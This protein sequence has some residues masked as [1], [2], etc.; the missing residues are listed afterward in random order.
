M[1]DAYPTKTTKPTEPDRI[2][3]SE[4][5]LIENQNPEI[6]YDRFVS[7]GGP[8]ITTETRHWGFCK[9]WVETVITKSYSNGAARNNPDGS[10]YPA[11]GFLFGFVYGW[12]GDQS[13]C[14]NFSVCP[15]SSKNIS[16]GNTQPCE[17][18]QKTLAKKAS[19]KGS[20]W[21]AAGAAEISSD[22][23][24]SGHYIQLQINV[25]RWGCHFPKKAPRVCGWATISAVGIYSPNVIKPKVEVNLSQ[26]YLNDID[27]YKSGNLDGTYYLEDAINI[28]HK[29]TYQWKQD[30]VGTLS[31]VVTKQYELSLEEEFQCESVRCNHTLVHSGFEPW[32]MVFEYGSGN[33]LYNA[34][35]NSEIRKHLLIYKVDLYNLGRLIYS[36]QNKTEPLVVLYEPQYDSYPYLILKDEHWWSWAN[37]QGVALKYEGSIGGGPDDTPQIHQ[38]RRSKINSHQYFGYAFDP[39]LPKQL[40]QTFLWDGAS[41]INLAQKCSNSE[42][43]STSF[44]AKGGTAMFV[45]AGFGKI[46]FSWPITK[47][48]LEKRYINATIQN[49]L[50]SSNFAGFDAKNL[51][52]YKYQYPDVKFQNPVK[53]LTYHSDGSRTALPVSVRLVPD[54]AK[55]AQYTQD[56]TCNK[57]LRDTGTPEFADIIVDGMYEKENFANGT[58]YVNMKTRLTSTWFAPFYSVIVNDTLDLP[59]DQ[60]YKALSPYEITISVGE[61]TRT[62]QR[63]VN[64]LS[65]FVHVVNLDSDNV[66]NVTQSFGFV[67]INPDEKFGEIAKVIINGKEL[68]ADCTSGCTTTINSNQ[69]LEIEAWNVWGGRAL[70]HIQGNVDVPSSDE[71]N[72]NLIFVAIIVAVVGLFLWRVAGQVLEYLGFRR[73]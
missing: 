64:F 53:I 33:T 28:V 12:A 41:L 58:G 9:I 60:G 55:N 31:V 68:G 17:T 19:K 13:K 62:I 26:E 20:T 61:K 49:T 27:G 3:Q 29:P 57:V 15:I 71:I 39:V 54:F 35:K 6:L 4:S 44:E 1:H 63:I 47:T 66:L 10:F 23:N 43:D 38:D 37:R 46:A 70:S 36:T 21:T 2:I 25:E 69:D 7:S 56:Y 18:K 30:R 48:M 42:I 45:K 51:T 73:L 32:Y 24:A 50:Q 52:A 14:R 59:I 8:E 67:R 11:D 16:P 72:W 34:T 5:Y 40:G 65:P 22:P